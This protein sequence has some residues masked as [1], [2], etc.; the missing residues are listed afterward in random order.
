MAAI[1]YIR[2]MAQ[3]MEQRVEELERRISEL[4]KQVLNLRPANKDWRSTVGSMPDDEMTREAERL[5]REYRKQ[6]SYDK[7]IA[8]S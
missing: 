4:T 6:Q 5:G 8:G 2:S 3:T 1:V 7:E